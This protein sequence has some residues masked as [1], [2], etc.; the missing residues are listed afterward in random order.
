M[1]CRLCG[2]RAGWLRRRC[3]RCKTLWELWQRNREASWRELF[4]AFLATDIAP[5]QIEKFLA[6]EPKKGAGSIRDLIAA[7]LT[8]HLLAA[9]GKSPTQSAREVKRL[10][11]KGLWRAYDRPLDE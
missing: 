6:A 11:E 1:R 4:D 7:D 9:L 3:A 5:E 2:E 10:R 8:N